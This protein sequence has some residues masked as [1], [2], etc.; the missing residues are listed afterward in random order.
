MAK[1]RLIAPIGP[2]GLYKVARELARKI[3][4]MGYKVEWLDVETP[5]NLD[6][7]VLVGHAN[8]LAFWRNK[9][10][11][12]IP[13]LVTE[14]PIDEK[15]SEELKRIG[16]AYV[17]SE[18]SADL[19]SKAGASASV[20]YPA[21][22]EVET[23]WPLREVVKPFDVAAVLSLHTAKEV[24]YR[25]GVDLIDASMRITEYLFAINKHLANVI[26]TTMART[27]IFTGDS[28]NDIY[29]LLSLSKVLLYPSRSEGFGLPV[30]EA[31][32]LGVPAVFLNVPALDEFACG[33]PVDV[34][35][36]PKIL[37]MDYKGI[38]WSMYAW[39]P[40]SKNKIIDTLK[41]ALLHYDKHINYCKN[42]SNTIKKLSEKQVEELLKH[43][44][45]LFS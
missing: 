2:T 9:I 13:Y 23:M 3:S 21:F 36:E 5:T 37:R 30:Y 7:A 15:A 43:I 20:A 41:D 38:M 29:T 8:H 32:A 34:K 16:H 27:V 26:N 17:M 10:K 28:D 1:V 11:T 22:Y 45:E 12:V 31:N 19:I 40:K 33:F 4:E 39:E 6:A 44:I 14:G 35:N 18:F 24:L 42:S 25:K